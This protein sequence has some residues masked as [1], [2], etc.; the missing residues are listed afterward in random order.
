MISEEITKIL[1]ESIEKIPFCER[2]IISSTDGLVIKAY[3]EINTG[4]M[5][6]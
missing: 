3:P 4:E 5:K 6:L 2:I 1:K